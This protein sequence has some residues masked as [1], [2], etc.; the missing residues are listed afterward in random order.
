M[1]R[2]DH[3]HDRGVFHGVLLLTGLILA[4]AIAVTWGWNTIVSQIGEPAGFRFA[5]GLA[6]ATMAVLAGALFEAGRRLALPR[7]RGDAE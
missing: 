3:D 4:G 6:V 2:H 7:R 5:E 1:I